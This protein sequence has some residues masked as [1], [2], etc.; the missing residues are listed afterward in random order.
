MGIPEDVTANTA[1]PAFSWKRMDEG[2]V[3]NK[4]GKLCVLLHYLK[5]RAATDVLEGRIKRKPK[6]YNKL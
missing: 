6:F 4:W 5:V 1:G 3:L 2:P